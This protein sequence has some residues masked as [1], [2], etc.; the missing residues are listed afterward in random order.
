MYRV[1]ALLEKNLSYYYVTPQRVCSPLAL[2]PVMLRIAVRC[3][4]LTP[5]L[6]MR[7]VHSIIQLLTMQ[8][9]TSARNA[10]MQGP[11][12]QCRSKILGDKYGQET[13]GADNWCFIQIQTSNI[14][15]VRVMPQSQYS[16]IQ[17]LSHMCAWLHI[18]WDGPASEL[19][20]DSRQGKH[21]N[22]QSTTDPSLTR[23]HHTC[24]FF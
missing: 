20:I 22:H 17:K 7:N 10:T 5:S 16:R 19:I 8:F 4:A 13:E 21:S 9:K 6:D 15:L 11:K 3:G 12:R 23:R 2:A 24:T 18:D 14:T 1:P